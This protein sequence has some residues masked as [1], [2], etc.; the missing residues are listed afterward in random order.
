MKKSILSI[1]L[2]ALSASAILLI[3][4][5]SKDDTAPVITLKGDNPMTISLNS[6]YSEP[7]ATASDDKDGD[8][9]ANI[10]ISGTVNK[11]LAGSY[12]ITY[13]VSD[14]EGNTGTETRTVNVVNDA[15]YLN[16][17]YTT[18][19]T[20]VPSWTQTVTASSTVN[21]RIVFSKFGNYSNNTNIHADVSGSTMDI[22]TQVATNIGSSGCT[23]TI[24]QDGPNTV[25]IA[26]VS[27]KWNFSVNYTD[28]QQ[29]GCGGSSGTPVPTVDLFTQ[30]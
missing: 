15:A 21:N 14:K 19:E 4:S 17:T 20:G 25:P 8:V 16:G 3:S 11:D 2:F 5:C 24:A 18:S 1:S 28:Q 12:D 13:T 26:Q 9:S 6:S 23:H 22:G 30:H 10:S 29:A 27:G 7:G